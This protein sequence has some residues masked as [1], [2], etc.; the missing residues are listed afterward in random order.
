MLPV[1]YGA[2]NIKLKKAIYYPTDETLRARDG[3][4]KV[5]AAVLGQLS[6]LIS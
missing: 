2:I 1:A 3:W 5:I 4:S 6:K